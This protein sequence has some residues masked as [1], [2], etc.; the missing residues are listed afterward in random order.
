VRAV[1]LT[2]TLDHLDAR[3]RGRWANQHFADVVL[4]LIDGR[5][6]RRVLEVGGGRRPLLAD[7]L[8][9]R[10]DVDYVI[11]DVSQDELDRL[12]ATY[13]T[14]CFDVQ[15]PDGIPPDLAGT[16]D[17]VF[18]KMVFEHVADPAS[19][20]TTVH[21]LLRPG[22][23]ALVYVPTLYSP[24]FVLNRLLPS[25]A[26]A[27]LLRR[28]FPNRTDDGVPKFPAYYR[29]CRGTAEPLTQ[30][31]LDI[32]FDRVD[33]VPFYGHS[34]YRRFPVVRTASER[35]TDVV[36]RRSMRTLSSFA[37]VGAVR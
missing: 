3:S 24:P 31:L 32:G 25:G 27:S 20:W 35:L 1:V 19:A 33:V 7:Q 21:R 8:A 15:D 22:G 30:R 4:A 23:V 17:V 12:P 26:S 28:V 34:Y 36:E 9:S 13:G 11:N 14:A 5:S 37:F 16:C 10:E 2:E 29:W 18:A 6:T